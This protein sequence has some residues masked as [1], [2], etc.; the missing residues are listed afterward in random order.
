MLASMDSRNTG[1]KTLLLVIPV[2]NRCPLLRDLFNGDFVRYADV[3]AVEEFEREAVPEILLNPPC[4][5]V[6]PI[7]KEMQ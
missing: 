4:A 3:M 2:W 1:D 5:P 6:F 7:N